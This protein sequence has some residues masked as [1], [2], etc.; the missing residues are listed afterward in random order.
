MNEPQISL[1][2]RNLKSRGHFKEDLNS[3]LVFKVKK[4]MR[5]AL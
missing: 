5:F 4:I 3:S 1:K 2:V